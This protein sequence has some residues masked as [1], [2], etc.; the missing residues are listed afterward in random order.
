[1]TKIDC[2]NISGLWKIFKLTIGTNKINPK[3]KKDTKHQE[4]TW[5]GNNL[6]PR[7][8]TN[9]FHYNKF[10][11]IQIGVEALLQTQIPDTPK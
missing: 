10:G 5:F 9:K 8:T 7:A 11:I 4:F 2:E 6:H 1:M 3:K